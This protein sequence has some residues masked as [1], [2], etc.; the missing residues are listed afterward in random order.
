MLFIHTTPKQLMALVISYS[1]KKSKKQ[2]QA[3]AAIYQWAMNTSQQADVRII[4]MKATITNI[5]IHYDKKDTQ[6][7][8]GATKEDV[9]HDT[10]QNRD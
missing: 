5:S 1:E 3:E 9:K 7:L 8:I 6:T 2:Q 4:L 10:L